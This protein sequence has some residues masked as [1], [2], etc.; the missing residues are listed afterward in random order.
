[1]I[2]G[3]VATQ[4]LRPISG[5]RGLAPAEIGKRHAASKLTVPSVACHHCSGFLVD[6]GDDEGSGVAPRDAEH[7][8][9]ICGHGKASGSTR[10]ILNSEAGDLDRVRQR[11]EV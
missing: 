1:M 11:Y 7:P 4:K 6:L 8:L 10:V 5:P 3:A 2:G 9:D